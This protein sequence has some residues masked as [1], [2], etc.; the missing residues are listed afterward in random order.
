MSTPSVVTEAARAEHE[1]SD[2]AAF[3]RIAA[4]L[5]GTAVLGSFIGSMTGEKTTFLFK[6]V[7]H[8][9]P[10]GIGTLGLIA[11]LSAYV[12]PFMGAGA[13]LYPVFG[14]HRRSYYLIGTLGCAAAWWGLACLHQYRYAAVV[15]LMMLAG[16]G[17]TMAS[18][19]VNAVMVAVGN[20]TRRF[21]QLQSVLVFVPAVL[22]IVYTARLGGY[23]TQHWTYHRAFGTAA[24]L[25][26]LYVP[27]VLLID[28]K[29]AARRAGTADALPEARASRREERAQVAATLATAARSPGLWAVLGFVF[30]LILTPGAGNAQI[31]FE[32]DVL[33]FSKQFIGN[34]G[35]FGA[36]GSIA[37]MLVFGGTSRRMPAYFLV[38]GAWLMDCLLYPMSLLLR[39][40]MSAEVVSF[41]GAAIGLWYGLCLN[42]LAARACPPGVEG[43]IYGL[44]MSIIAIAGALCGVLGGKLYDFFGPLNHAH[45]WSITHGWVCSLWF[46]LAFTLVGFVFIPFLPKWAKSH[47]PLGGNAV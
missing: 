30:Y 22:S 41:A 43:T 25:I 5:V 34:L 37:G 36:A 24:A 28:E 31:F 42:T 33:H 16:F 26:L 27:L 10:G 4:F 15:C 19:M 32:T 21:G 11:G 40:P 3:W 45:H 2:L 29:P 47:E 1:S 14:S 39:G 20:K 7:M 12:Q 23:I 17:G 13:D 44:V 46:G 8:L 9:T 38:W 6:D 18:V 35:M